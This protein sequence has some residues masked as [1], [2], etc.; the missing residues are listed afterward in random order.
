MTGLYFVLDKTT[1]LENRSMYAY[2][3]LSRSRLLLLQMC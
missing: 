3:M 2:F 1:P